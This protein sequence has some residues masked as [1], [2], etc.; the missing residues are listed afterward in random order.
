MTAFPAPD[1]TLLAHHTA[2]DGPPLVCLPGGPMHPAAYLGDLGGLTA[3][4]RLTAL[5]PR[6]TGASEVPADPASYRCDRLVADVEALRRHLGVDRVDVLGHS[7]GANLAVRYAERHPDRVDRLVLVTPSTFGVGVDV[8]GPLRART[9]RLREGE[10]WFPEAYAALE[11][12]AA[13]RATAASW[14]A[15]AP[16]M[17][18]RWDEAARAHRA[19]GTPWRGTEAA[20][21][22]GAD[23]AFDPPATRAALAAFDR[24]VLLVAGELDLNSPPE[25]V[26]SYAALFPDARLAVL[27]GVSHFPWVDDPRG[28]ASAVAGFL[29]RDPRDGRKQDA[30]AA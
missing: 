21:A 1:G 17:Y 13:G 19:L 26:T 6:G 5:D 4:R 25:A 9:A 14:E 29:G 23:G 16:F 11:D 28:F 12:V 30:T 20:A 15:M 10:P 8:P 22:Y 27:P 2:G 18:A 24:P 3:H 7:A